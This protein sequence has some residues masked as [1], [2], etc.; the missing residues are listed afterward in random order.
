MHNYYNPERSSSFLRALFSRFPYYV[1]VGE[2]NASITSALGFL[3]LPSKM[4]QRG[5]RTVGVYPRDPRL[6]ADNRLTRHEEQSVKQ[7][8]CKLFMRHLAKQQTPSPLWDQVKRVISCVFLFVF[9]FCV[10]I[11]GMWPHTAVIGTMQL[12][13]RN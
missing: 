2:A 6:Q 11:V 5:N 3:T 10:L 13:P 9:F 1:L 4:N 12:P 8:S 7:N